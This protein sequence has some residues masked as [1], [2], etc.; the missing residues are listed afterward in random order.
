VILK[1]VS[2]DAEI[3]RVSSISSFALFDFIVSSVKISIGKKR[4]LNIIT[5]NNYSL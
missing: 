3:P 5:F 1:S 2:D 4:T